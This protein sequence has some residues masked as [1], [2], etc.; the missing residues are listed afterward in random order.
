MGR[1]L[2]VEWQ[3]TEAELKQGYRREKHRQKRERLLVLW[4]LRQGKRVEEVAQMTGIAYRLIQR[5]VSWYRQG[6]LD[7]V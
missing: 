7:E 5:W 1:A 3:E 4:H 2:Q 6:G